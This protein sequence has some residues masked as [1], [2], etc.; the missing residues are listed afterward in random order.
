[1]IADRPTDPCLPPCVE[2]PHCHAMVERS[3]IQR[4]IAARHPDEFAAV[5][6][7]REHELADSIGDWT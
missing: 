7:V 2:C 4:H 3:R 6:L 1:M 5:V